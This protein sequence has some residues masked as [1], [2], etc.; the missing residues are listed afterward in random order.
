[1]C[2]HTY[3]RV[4]V[5]VCVCTDDSPVQGFLSPARGTLAGANTPGGAAAA[6]TLSPTSPYALQEMQRHGA[7]GGLGAGLGGNNG[8]GV[9]GG[10]GG[11]GGQGPHNDDDQDDDDL[12]S[13]DL[14]GKWGFTPGVD[15][16][17]E[18]D[19]GT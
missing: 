3:E 19:K 9:S 2:W 18:M 17:L 13:A 4:C 11:S 14:K 1:M 12:G 10:A 8:A 15:D 16:T 7:L 6:N 5:C